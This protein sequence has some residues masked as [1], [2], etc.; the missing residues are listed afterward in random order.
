MFGDCLALRSRNHSD[1]GGILVSIEGRAFTVPRGNLRLEWLG[2]VPAAIPNVAGQDLAR[3]LL[4]GEPDP[5]RV[6]FLLYE[7]PEFIRLSL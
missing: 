3:L 2:A 6:R 5:P 1:V 7:A 4:Q